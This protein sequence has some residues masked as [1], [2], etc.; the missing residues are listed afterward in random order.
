MAVQYLCR[1]LRKLLSTSIHLK[2]ITFFG[3]NMEIKA[4]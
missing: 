1:V 4:I 2:V 3:P